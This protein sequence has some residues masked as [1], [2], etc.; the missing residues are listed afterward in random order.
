MEACPHQSFS[1]LVAKNSFLVDVSCSET[2]FLAPKEET[3]RPNRTCKKRVVSNQDRPP[4]ITDTEPK[5][6]Y[7]MPL[8]DFDSE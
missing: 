4:S 6:A 7:Q 1:L 5:D 2:R 3:Y 8:S